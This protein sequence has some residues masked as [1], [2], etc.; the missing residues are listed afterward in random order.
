MPVNHAI[1]FILP[2]FSE[3]LN[4]ILPAFSEE[5]NGILPA[6]SEKNR[7]FCPLFRCKGTLFL[8]YTQVFLQKKNELDII[9][10]IFFL[11]SPLASNL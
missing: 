9:Q 6:F 3:E 8:W 1:L 5:L 4:G 7:L 2:A 10:L 11:S